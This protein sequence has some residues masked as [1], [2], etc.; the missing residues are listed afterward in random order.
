MEHNVLLLKEF[1]P[2]R[3]VCAE[4]TVT[5]YPAFCQSKHGTANNLDWIR[6]EGI[7]QDGTISIGMAPRRHTGHYAGSESVVF[8]DDRKRN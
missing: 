1:R 3:V 4:E 5:V 8:S 7:R 2:Y 6:K